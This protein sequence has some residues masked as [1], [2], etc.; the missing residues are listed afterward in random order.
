M[1]VGAR[2]YLRCIYHK[3][4]IRILNCFHINIWT[5]FL[6]INYLIFSWI[7][8]EVKKTGSIFYIKSYWRLSL[9][10]FWRLPYEFNYEISK[11]WEYMYPKLTWGSCVRKIRMLG[12]NLEGMVLQTC[13]SGNYLNIWLDMKYIK[14]QV[15]QIEFR[16]WKVHNKVHNPTSI[17]ICINKIFFLYHK[18]N[19]S[20][21]WRCFY[22]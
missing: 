16:A 11:Y 18:F 22:P 9:H 14:S 5:W 2:F 20:C 13:C 8:L 10:T 3:L 21:M 15:T 7:L 17:G 1:D 6:L 4:I 19:M 12:K